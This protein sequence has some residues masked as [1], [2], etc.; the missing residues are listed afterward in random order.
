ML[1]VRGIYE[2]GQ[3]QLLES[4]PYNRRINVII[5][6]LEETIEPEAVTRNIN[7]N[8]FDSLVGIINERENGSEAH[9]RYLAETI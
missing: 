3:I 6:V 1:S 4:I 2:N 8:A 9:D 5:T 7:I